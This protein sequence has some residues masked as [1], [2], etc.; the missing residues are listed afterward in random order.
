MNRYIEALRN[1]IECDKIFL[2]NLAI[3]HKDVLMRIAQVCAEHVDTFY[4]MYE[5]GAI[6]EL[7]DFLDGNG[8]EFDG[9]PARRTH[10][11][12]IVHPRYERKIMIGHIVATVK[13]TCNIEE[14]STPEIITCSITTSEAEDLKE[15]IQNPLGSRLDNIEMKIAVEAAARPPPR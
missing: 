14:V 7:I 6:A 8:F 13:V 11:L 2:D 1:F 3:Q 15:P 10:E 5:N 4:I 9:V 12:I